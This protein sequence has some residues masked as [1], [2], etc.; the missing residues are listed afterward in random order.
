MKIQMDNLQAWLVLQEHID[1]QALQQHPNPIVRQAL[2]TVDASLNE[3]MTGEDETD[4]IVTLTECQDND[5]DEH[6]KWLVEE[7]QIVINPN[8]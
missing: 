2:D 1:T 8:K 4:V 3:R 7:S 6:T 5:W